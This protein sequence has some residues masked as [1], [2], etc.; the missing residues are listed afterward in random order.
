MPEPDDLRNPDLLA[1]ASRFNGPPESGNGGYVAGLLAEH[2]AG[3]PAATV[4][5][6][7]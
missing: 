4:T 2:L 5:L 7:Q 6:R 1:V 3:R